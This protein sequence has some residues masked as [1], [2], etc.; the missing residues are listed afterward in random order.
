MQIT[1]DALTALWDMMCCHHSFRP[2]APIFDF[3][4]Y[5]LLLR[6]KWTLG[7][8]NHPDTWIHGYKVNPLLLLI[9]NKWTL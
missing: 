9:E 8:K 2:A 7:D 4:Q 5:W 6:I 3:E 1:E